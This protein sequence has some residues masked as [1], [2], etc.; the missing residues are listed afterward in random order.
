MFSREKQVLNA[1]PQTFHWIF[2]DA[3]SPF[4][5]FLTSDT[6][7]FWLRGKPGSGKSTLTKFLSSHVKT[8]ELLSQ[9]ADGRPVLVAIHFFWNSGHVMQKNMEGLLRNLLYQ[10]FQQRPEL[11][12]RCCLQRCDDSSNMRSMPRPW[13]LQELSE[14]FRSIISSPQLEERFCFFIDGLDEYDGDQC[15]LVQEIAA[16]SYKPH[17]KFCVSSRPWNVFQKAYGG[18]AQKRLILEELTREDMEAFVEGR[19]TN[20]A[21]FMQLSDNDT[22]A[23]HGTRLRILDSVDN[24]YERDTAQA[25]L[26][27]LEPDCRY[28]PVSI[29]PDLSLLASNPDFAL[30]KVVP[31]CPSNSSAERCGRAVSYLNKWC[32]GLLE[33]GCHVCRDLPDLGNA[34][35]SVRFLHRTVRDFLLEPEQEQLLAHRAGR[36]FDPRLAS[37]HLLLAQAKTVVARLGT[38]PERYPLTPSD[39][40]FHNSQDLC[41]SEE[42]V[43]EGVDELYFHRNGFVSLV[44]GIML[45]CKRV[46]ITDGICPMGVLTELDHAGSIWVS[47]KPGSKRYQ[48][49]WTNEFYGLTDPLFVELASDA[50]KTL[51]GRSSDDRTCD[52]FLALAVCYELETYVRQALAQDVG[53]LLGLGCRPLIDYALFPTLKLGH[54]LISSISVDMIKLLLDAGASVNE[55]LP[56]PKDDDMSRSLAEYHCTSWKQFLL[57]CLH[58]KPYDGEETGW[59]ESEETRWWRSRLLRVAL[60]LLE[61]GADVHAKVYRAKTTDFTNEQSQVKAGTETPNDSCDSFTAAEC[62]QACCPPSMLEELNGALDLATRRSTAAP[63]EQAVA[64]AAP[65]S[66]VFRPRRRRWGTVL[67]GWRRRP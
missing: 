41:S 28:L 59:W 52:S 67:R 44:E 49:H 48:R 9:W 19:L 46:E 5:N 24:C 53:A 54:L 47:L 31:A 39:W 65:D 38:L 3:T 18:V 17:A 62:L 50:H 22:R 11:I 30:E 64:G 56:L 2:E 34:G 25:F 12:P 13:S 33:V 66:S 20:D 7:V 29:L 40:N 27:S 6:G 4:K 63:Q 45:C 37:C 10:I 21:R 1:Y 60:F 26:I 61:H 51:F 15:E 23:P 57:Y 36:R 14:T 32:R 58:Y 8:R 43:E 42:S 16:L 35:C 55:R